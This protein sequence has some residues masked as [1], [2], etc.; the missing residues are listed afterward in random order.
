MKFSR[1]DFEMQRFESR[2]PRLESWRIRFRNAEVRIPAAPATQSV[3][4]ASHMKVE[5]GRA[6]RLSWP[7]LRDA[8][9]SVPPRPL[10]HSN[11]HSPQPEQRHVGGALRLIQK[12][13]TTPTWVPPRR[14]IAL[15]HRPRTN[16]A[17]PIPLRH[18]PPK[19]QQ[20]TMAG[21]RPYAPHG[22]LETR[23]RVCRAFVVVL[24]GLASLHDQQLAPLRRGF[25]VR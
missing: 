16:N 18:S 25:F 4:N 21:R 15:A 13:Q 12:R 1:S 7:P 23:H 20:R 9:T 11:A 2:R 14:R 6:V 17:S 22:Y 5:E 8:R 10:R 3:S 24:L 19:S